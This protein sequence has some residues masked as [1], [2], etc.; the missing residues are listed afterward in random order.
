MRF[1]VLT[2]CFLP[3][4]SWFF[5]SRSPCF[6]YPS[7]KDHAWASSHEAFSQKSPIKVLIY[8]FPPF[9]L[10]WDIFVPSRLRAKTWVIPKSWSCL[11]H[12]TWSKFLFSPFQNSHPKS[13]H[14]FLIS[15]IQSYHFQGFRL[16]KTIQDKVLSL[17]SHVFKIILPHPVQICWLGHFSKFGV[18]SLPLSSTFNRLSSKEGHLWT[19]QNFQNITNIPL[20]PLIPFS[21]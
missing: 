1:L 21:K 2:G 11:T 10:S 15:I 20:L 3:V 18:F 14:D 7:R 5:S 13:H 17:R 4:P 6:V 9:G 8:S 19:P 16:P 12:E